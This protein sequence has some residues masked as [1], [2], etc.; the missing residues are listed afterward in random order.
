VPQLKL[1]SPAKAGDPVF[2]RPALVDRGRGVL[3]IRFRGYDD[4][5]RRDDC[6]Y[7]SCRSYFPA[8]FF[9]AA[10]IEDAASS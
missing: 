7:L 3:D 6:A 1:S 2:Q 9:I 8:S 10:L 4:V 5:A